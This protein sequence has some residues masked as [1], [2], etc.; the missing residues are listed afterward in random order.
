[1]K[2]KK[3]FLSSITITPLAISLASCS[4][5]NKTEEKEI[6]EN[7]YIENSAFLKKTN[8][9]LASLNS[10][11]LNDIKKTN[12][13]ALTKIIKTK[14][15]LYAKFNLPKTVEILD[16]NTLI[17]ANVS[18]DIEDDEIQIFNSKVIYGSIENYPSLKAKLIFY[19]NENYNNNQDLE[20]LDDGL[21]P[22]TSKLNK[23]ERYWYG[24]H[25]N[26]LPK[27]LDRGDA[28]ES[29]QSVWFNSEDFNEKRAKTFFIF[30]WNRPKLVSKMD[31]TFL[32]YVSRETGNPVKMPNEILIQVSNDGLSW[33]N[34]KN[35]DKVKQSD[36]PPFK[37]HHKWKDT[38][39][40][41]TINF[42][43]TETEWIRVLWK[44]ATN[45][46]NQLLSIFVTDVKFYGQ[47]IIDKNDNIQID[48]NLDD[49]KIN[50]LSAKKLSKNTFEINNI[51][52]VENI[53]LKYLGK[54][55]DI[56]LFDENK[57]KS[58]YKI[59]IYN[60]IGNYKI[61]RCKI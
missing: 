48:I 57:E 43:P 39:A 11:D 4:Q 5:I 58:I 26:K 49:V 53:D 2:F 17:S 30:K 52:S 54:Y 28:S 36:F 18:W 7:E 45:A 9:S 27:L 51:S 12:L 61:C 34:V 50:K 60:E 55:Y 16:N 29:N 14:D 38:F 19:K 23:D 8:F 25:I 46:Q 20:L 56:I 33:N 15:K 44:P 1:M 3:I 40:A 41:Q 59:A 22:N 21:A 32:N 35:Q 37:P 6:K 24:I 13:M 47:S 31:I 42:A 10:L